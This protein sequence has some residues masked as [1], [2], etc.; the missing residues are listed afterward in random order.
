VLSD[1]LF[2][3]LYK[4]HPPE[5]WRGYDTVDGR[6]TFGVMFPILKGKQPRMHCSDSEWPFSTNPISVT[7]LTTTQIDI[8]WDLIRT[9][10]NLVIFTRLYHRVELMGSALP[11]FPSPKWWPLRSGLRH[12][13]IMALTLAEGVEKLHS[14]TLF[15]SFPRSLVRTCKWIFH[16]SARKPR[17]QCINQQLCV[18]LQ[19]RNK[20]CCIDGVKRGL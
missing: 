2:T 20:F 19:S 7:G 1:F 5:N 15:L 17:N 11:V 6:H 10:S 4:T 16:K 8:K 12:F 9:F 3:A 14:E 13:T 18:Y